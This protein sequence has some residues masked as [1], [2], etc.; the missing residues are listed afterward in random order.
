[1]EKRKSV[2]LHAV[3]TN[4]YKDFSRDLTKIS[5][6]FEELL[7]QDSGAL[8]LNYYGYIL[9]DHEVDVKKGMKYVNKALKLQPE[10]S[11]YLDSLAWGHY[12]LGECKK[13]LEVIQRVRKLDGGNDAEVII[14]HDKIKQCKG[15]K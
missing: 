4:D 2:G 1:M 3:H 5:K 11:Y 14:H 13:A 12:K 7:S 10:S 8:Y 9:I 6:R 15:K